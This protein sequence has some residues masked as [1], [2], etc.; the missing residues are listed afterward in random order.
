M[1]LRK[2]KQKQIDSSLLRNQTTKQG[3]EQMPTKIKL[4]SLML[5]YIH[6]PQ[7]LIYCRVTEGLE[8]SRMGRQSNAGHTSIYTH[9]Y[10]NACEEASLSNHI[11]SLWDEIDPTTQCYI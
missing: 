11:S 9:E 10:A 6:L 5:W 3:L 8:A 4:I 2:E 1:L 7:L